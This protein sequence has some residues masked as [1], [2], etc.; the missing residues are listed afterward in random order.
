MFWPDF[1]V[2]KTM[3][4]FNERAGELL[5]DEFLLFIFLLLGP[6]VR[7]EIQ[8]PHKGIINEFLT[9]SPRELK[10]ASR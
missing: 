9:F 5:E 8:I 4:D 1:K 7:P 2:F 6:P 10:A 3:S